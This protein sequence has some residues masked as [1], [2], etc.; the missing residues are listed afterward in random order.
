MPT[1]VTARE[2]M[3]SCGDFWQTVDGMY[4]YRMTKILKKSVELASEST[5]PSEDCLSDCGMN[6]L[7]LPARASFK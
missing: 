7:S 1:S 3:T 4:Y 6:V 2:K 5:L